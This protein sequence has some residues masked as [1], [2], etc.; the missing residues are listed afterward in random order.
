MALVSET[1]SRQRIIDADTGEPVAGI[2]MSRDDAA[3]AGNRRIDASAIEVSF[4]QRDT[5]AL[6]QNGGF[7]FMRRIE[8]APGHQRNVLLQLG[9][10]GARIA[11][12]QAGQEYPADEASSNR[13]GRELPPLTRQVDGG[14]HQHLVGRQILQ[15]DDERLM[16]Q[17]D[18]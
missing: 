9:L 13:V 11:G 7:Q 12:P 1:L 17:D 5:A 4:L 14:R 15:T 8:V 16:T 2:A 18:H 10:A 6:A 3:Q